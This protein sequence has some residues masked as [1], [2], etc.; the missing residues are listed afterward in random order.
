MLTS[1]SIIT[2][3][4]FTPVSSRRRRR[5]SLGCS[6]RESGGAVDETYRQARHPARPAATAAVGRAARIATTG[7]RQDEARGRQRGGRGRDEASQ[8]DYAVVVAGVRRE[9]VQRQWF[10]AVFAAQ[11]GC[12]SDKWNWVE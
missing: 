11:G 9:A 6:R 12:V 2:I 10:L 8:G 7:A 5:T 1:D 3:R 4:V